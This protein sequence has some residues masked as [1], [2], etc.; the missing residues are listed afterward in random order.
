MRLNRSLGRLWEYE[1]LPITSQFH[2]NRL[3]VTIARNSNT[4]CICEI[5]NIYCS[6][7]PQ[8][9]GIQLH[10]GSS[11]QIGFSDSQDH[12]NELV[13]STRGDNLTSRV[14]SPRDVGQSIGEGVV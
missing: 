2:W 5:I 11:N 7:D 6:Y 9:A 4:Q 14:N 13:R 10:T 8:I 3:S 1:G 12:E